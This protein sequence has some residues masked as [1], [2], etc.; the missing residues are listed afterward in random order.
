M[1]FTLSGISPECRD[2]KPGNRSGHEWIRD[3][4]KE[5]KPRDPTAAE[6]INTYRIADDKEQVVDPIRRVTRVSVQTREIT[7]AMKAVKRESDTAKT[8]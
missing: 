3:Q 5:K 4:H 7:E 1:M 2:Y 6:K 8:S